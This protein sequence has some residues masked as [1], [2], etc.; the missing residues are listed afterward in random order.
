MVSIVAGQIMGMS[1]NFP[2][3]SKITANTG[4]TKL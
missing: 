4:Q 3:R 2:T 1:V